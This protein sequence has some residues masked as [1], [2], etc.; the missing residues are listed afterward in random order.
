MSNN[1]WPGNLTFVRLRP[2]SDGNYDLWRGITDDTDHYKNV[3]EAD[4]SDS[5]LV[6]DD[7]NNSENK[8]TF[9]VASI[10]TGKTIRAI[11][12]AIRRKSSQAT[13][14]ANLIVV[15][16]GS[17]DYT[18]DVDNPEDDITAWEYTPFVTTTGPTDRGPQY[19]DTLPSGGTLTNASVSALEIGGESDLDTGLG[20]E[21]VP[22]SDVT[23]QW[24]R[25]AGSDNFALIDAGTSSPDDSDYIESASSG[26]E[27]QYLVA[28][29]TDR[30]G[31]LFGSPKMVIKFRAKIQS[32]SASSVEGAVR[33]AS[34]W[35]D[36]D[37]S[38]SVSG[39]TFTTYTIGWA[40]DPRDSGQWF[41]ED[42]PDFE[43]FSLKHLDAN[44]TVRI[45]EA[46]LQ[47]SYQPTL[48]ISQTSILAVHDDTTEVI[49]PIPNRLLLV[50]LAVD[51]SNFF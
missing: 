46:N 19:W 20:D 11:K 10:S 32:G 48:R 30:E 1:S 36:V 47:V 34:T 29:P 13:S 17:T 15:R 39:G 28:T 9:G 37:S 40:L 33:I 38:A 5:D 23:Q 43:G 31:F 49:D 4:V 42:A 24:T 12:T 14:T 7:L 27:D 26:D 35:Y 41:S 18:V 21:L 3:D 51:R 16:E 2:D 22:T 25:S 50:D 6:V 8:Q 45:S 44:G